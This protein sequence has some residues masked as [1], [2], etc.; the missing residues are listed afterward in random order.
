MHTQQNFVTPRVKPKV[1]GSDTERAGRPLG[2]FCLVQVWTVRS[3]ERHVAVTKV[4][5]GLHKEPWS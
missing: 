1:I 2:G 4:R 5:V 3:T